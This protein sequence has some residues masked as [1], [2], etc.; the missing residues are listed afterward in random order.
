ME[1]SYPDP[2][3]ASELRTGSQ[4]E[5]L[6]SFLLILQYTITLPLGVE[7]H[8][9]IHPTISHATLLRRRRSV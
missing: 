2:H 1:R 6:N 9:L 3:Q 7:T 4:Y 8:Q 5:N